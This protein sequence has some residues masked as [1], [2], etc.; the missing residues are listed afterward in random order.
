MDR[1]ARTGLIYTVEM[2][3]AGALYAAALFARKPL[4]HLTADGALHALILLSPIVPLVLMGAA[5]VRYY[6]RLDEYGRWQFL[7]TVAIC[8]GAAAILTSSYPFVKDAFGLHDISI[9][10]AWP[11][12][13][14]CWFVASMVAAYRG[15]AMI[16]ANRP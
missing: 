15:R 14:A 1:E 10:Y 4:L 7:Q 9:M 2:L 11:V 8:T 12:L 6:F 16:R 3:G 5:I 13:G